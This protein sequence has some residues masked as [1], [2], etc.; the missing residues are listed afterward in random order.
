MFNAIIESLDLREIIL[1][2]RQFTWTNRRDTP[3]YEK[4]DRILASVEWEQKF[5]LVSVR[6]LTRSGSDHT[7]LLIDSGVKAHLG[8]KSQFSFELYWL[9]HEGFY[10]MIAKEWNSVNDGRNPMEQWQ[11]KIRHL[12]RFLKGWAKNLSGKYKK[13]KERLLSI[14][15][16]LDLKAENGPLSIHERGMLRDANERITNLR[17]DEETKWAQR[18]KVKHIQEG[19][20]NMKYFHLIANG[21]HRN[22]NIFQLEQEE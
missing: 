20:N 5:P 18:A 12:R 8:N 21:K 9:R 22:K 13:E 11:N 2:G 16:D 3:T 14:I 6:A 1:S 15:D 19:G 4:L 10:D 17:R 7:P